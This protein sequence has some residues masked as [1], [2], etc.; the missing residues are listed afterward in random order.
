MTLTHQTYDCYTGNGTEYKG[1]VHRTKD[2]EL[3][4]KWDATQVS[5]STV[6]AKLFKTVV[7]KLLKTVVAKLFK[8]GGRKTLQ[9]WGLQ[10]SSKL[11]LQNSSKLGVAKLFKTGVCTCKN[12]Q[13]FDHVLF[14]LTAFLTFKFQPFFTF[15]TS[16]F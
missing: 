12:L 6:V 2:G 11:G 8:T 9:N 15:Y 13:S 16:W 7:A 14:L 4:Q 3:C 1:H 10:N 5:L